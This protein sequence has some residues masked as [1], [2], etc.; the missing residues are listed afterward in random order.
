MNHPLNQADFLLYNQ[1]QYQPINQQTRQ[2]LNLVH[3]LQASPLC[4]RPANQPPAL[5]LSRH[6]NLLA[7]RR[8]S[9]LI[10]RL[11]ARLL[12]HRFSRLLSRL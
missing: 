10:N 2:L 5:L 1:Q 11:E 8:D 3:H 9:L 12:S 6:P 7:I 4:F